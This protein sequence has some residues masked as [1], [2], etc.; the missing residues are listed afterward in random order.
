MELDEDRVDAAV[1][2]L[3]SLT[4]HDGNRAW[5]SFDWDT[6][7]RLHQQ[8]FIENPVNTAKSVTL[9]PE[10]IRRS[11]ELLAQMFGKTRKKE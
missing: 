10:G 5:K 2:G 9:T 7:S 6:L 1:L 8:G 3:L 11:E 4:L